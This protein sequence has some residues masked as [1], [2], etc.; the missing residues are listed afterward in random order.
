MS[1]INASTTKS[2]SPNYPAIPLGEAVAIA[3][4]LRAKEGDHTFLADVAAGHLGYSPRSSGWLQKLGALKAFG[5]LEDVGSEVG[6]RLKIS[7]L[8]RVILIAPRGSPSRATALGDAMWKPAQ[9][10]VLRE[11]F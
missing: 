5:L 1:E 9:H 8:G 7:P 11:K 3:Q 4:T 10:Q 2:R 6:R